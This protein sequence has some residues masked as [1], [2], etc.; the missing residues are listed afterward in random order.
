DSG[1]YQL[2]I[3]DFGILEN[4][5]L[6][7]QERQAP[8]PG[9]VE[10][11]VRA[12][13]L[14]FRDVLNALG[15]LKE[16]TA[17]MGIERAEEIPFGGECSGVVVAVG[18]GVDRL[19]V[20]DEVMAVQAIGC[21]ASTVRVR[22]EFVIAKP[23]SLSFAAAATVPTAF[24]T[25]YYG[26][27]KQ[28]KL[29]AG[30]RILIH[31][32]AGGVGQAAVQL[33]Q[34]A[35]ATVW[36]TASPP[37][38]EFLTRMGVERVMNSRTLD[39]KEDIMTA[40][41]GRGV[42]VVLNSLNGEFIPASLDVVTS[43]GRFVEIG[44]IGIWDAEQVEQKRDDIEYLPFDL[45][46]LSLADP[47]LTQEWLSELMAQ[48][49]AGQLNALPYQAFELADAVEAFRF[50]AQ[51]K[52]RGKVV[53]E[54]PVQHE[55]LVKPDASY[56]I[57]GG[58]GALGLRVAEW[59]A[60]RG[61][62]HL[63]LTSRRGLTERAEAAIAPLTEIAEVKV[64]AADVANPADVEQMLSEMASELP[65]LKRVIHAAGVLDD[66]VLQ[67]QSWERFE[68]VMAPKVAGTWNLHQGTRELSLD[69][70]ACF[71][72][73]ASLLGAP[74]QGNYAAANGFMDGLAEYRRGQGL[75]GLSINW[76]PWS[77]GGMAA[78]LSDRDHLRWDAQGIELLTPDRGLQAFD[79]LLDRNGQ[80]G[81]LPVNWN[82]F[83]AQFPRNADLLFLERFAAEAAPEPAQ[84]SALLEQL[85]CAGEG[86][87]L[88][89]VVAHVREQLA[90]VLG[91]ASPEGIGT[92]DRLF[93][94]GLDSLMAVELKNR[95]ESSFGCTLRPTLMFDYP[96]IEALAQYLATEVLPPPVNS[97]E[98][99]DSE[100]AAIA[101]PESA[102]P[103]WAIAADDD[104]AALMATLESISDADLQLQLRSDR[105][106]AWVPQ[107]SVPQRNG[108][109]SL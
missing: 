37:K 61:A 95:M 64:V 76:G 87:R 90:R 100:I 50:M 58:L 83:L 66:G 8:A 77:T 4:L 7:P 89:M 30:D 29:Q 14:N 18:E 105:R 71:S 24:L 109:P 49:E 5:M 55:A 32:A 104:L 59:L 98:D 51:A 62:K 47:N 6:M 40:T 103:E 72:S 9:E 42:D 17:Q 101:E 23:S 54:M 45:L 36:G 94:L 44:K 53:I 99:S 70:F 107:R 2:R 73:V 15:M 26:L 86:D 85:E 80:V 96:T 65:P 67:Q 69:F 68:Q 108:A 16:F 56:L 10:I 93:D 88:T 21:L 12:V 22:Q 3:S 97:A 35:G 46:D 74:G 28:A 43:G 31:S 34:S 57:T 75:P 20:G 33:A 84:K 106:R 1:D 102:A 25:A 60:E 91:L 52:H 81:V 39:F 92:R 11:A 41:D 38:W 27:M 79:R 78:T 13:G 82:R 63:V 48:F 19:Q